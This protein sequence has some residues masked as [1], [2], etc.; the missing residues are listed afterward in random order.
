MHFAGACAGSC[1]GVIIGFLRIVGFGLVCVPVIA[2]V[3]LDLTVA[4]TLA[5]LSA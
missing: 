3:V 2:L 5:K 1:L 4:A